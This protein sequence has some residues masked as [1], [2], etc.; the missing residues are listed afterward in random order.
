[1]KTFGLWLEQ[2]QQHRFYRQNQINLS[3]SEE[4]SSNPSS[5]PFHSPRGSLPRGVIPNT[6]VHPNYSWPF[7]AYFDFSR[8]T[9][10]SKLFLA[11]NEKKR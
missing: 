6:G 9:R 5:L 7:F 10:N 1:M 8:E 3:N 2:L 11:R 4:I